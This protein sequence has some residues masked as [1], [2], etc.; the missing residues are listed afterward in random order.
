MLAG[1]PTRRGDAKTLITPDEDHEALVGPEKRAESAHQEVEHRLGFV[2]LGGHPGHI[3]LGAHHRHIVE[4][5][6]ALSHRS[7]VPRRPLRTP[8]SKVVA[9]GLN[10]PLRGSSVAPASDTAQDRAAGARVPS[11][12]L[13]HRCAIL[14]P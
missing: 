6:G 10:A 13:E 2:R 14:G 11:C 7:C 9:R 4:I 8:I 5:V 3:R 1:E 12:V